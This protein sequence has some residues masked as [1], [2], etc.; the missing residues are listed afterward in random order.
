MAYFTSLWKARIIENCKKEY[1]DEK[2][3]SILASNT[4]IPRKTTSVM[5]KW[6]I[7]RRNTKTRVTGKLKKWFP[8]GSSVSNLYYYMKKDHAC[9]NFVLKSIIGFLGGIVLT[10]LCF[11]FFVFQLSISLMHATIMSSVIGV[12]L[13]L[14]LAFSYRIRY[15]AFTFYSTLP[16]CSL[17]GFYRKSRYLSKHSSRL[18]NDRDRVKHLK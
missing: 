7:Y 13:T 12:L 10:Y 17:L 3:N 18:T 16:F 5:Q 6:R 14:G 15:D 2:I 9:P 11:M 1:E 8:E 4:E